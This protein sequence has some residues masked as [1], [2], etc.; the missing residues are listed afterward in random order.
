MA[1][2][3]R[4]HKKI[5]HIVAIDSKLRRN[6]KP[7]ELLGIYDPHSADDT[8]PRVVRWSVDR[9]RYWLSVGA[10][11]S[12]SV[13]KLLQLVCPLY[14]FP[15]LGILPTG[16]CFFFFLRDKYCGLGHLTILIPS[17]YRNTR[18]NTPDVRN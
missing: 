18:L 12:K 1:M 4:T 13:A 11:P 7:T 14:F 3:G 10:V 6:A 15:G 17:Y 8:N 16:L 2:H 5:F 9:L